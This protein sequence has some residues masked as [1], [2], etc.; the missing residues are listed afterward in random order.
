MNTIK[1]LGNKKDI[2][3]PRFKGERFASHRMPLELL[4]DF[5]VLQEMTVEMAKQIYLEENQSRQRVPKD[6]GK[7]I[8]F[9]LESLDEGSTIPKIVM[10]FMLSGMFPAHNVEY[11]EKASERIK[12]TIQEA[13]VDGNILEYAPK[14]VLYYFNRFG[15]KLKNDESIEFRPEDSQFKAVF[16]K[17]TRRRLVS[18]STS[19]GEYSED[20]SIRGVLVEMDKINNTFQIITSLGKK[21]PGSFNNEIKDQFLEA[22]SAL[23]GQQK[24]ILKGT[25]GFSNSDKL[26]KVLGVES[27]AVLDKNDLGYRLDEISL[28]KDG[29]FNGEGKSFDSEKLEWFLENYDNIIALEHIE[30]LAFPTPEGYLQLEWST[31]DIEASF[32][33]DLENRSAEFSNIHLNLSND[34]TTFVVDLTKNQG[35][36]QFKEELEKLFN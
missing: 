7:G 12:D 23:D 32:L 24:V 25:G 33:I 35:W 6:F 29:W 19:T 5:K 27:L 21:I 2:F 36:L 30:T 26:K 15:K 22:F 10:T 13:A 3:A 16:T 31:D 14:S 28:L 9:E 1:I 17:N 4:E 20:I 18:A 34:E 8:N 11:F